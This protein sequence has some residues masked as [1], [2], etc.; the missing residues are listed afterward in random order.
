MFTCANPDCRKAFDY[1]Q[2]QLVRVRI[3][4]LK[5]AS[6][7]RL[8]VKHFWLCGDCFELYVLSLDSGRI[9]V[10]PRPKQLTAGA[11]NEGS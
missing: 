10:K 9:T 6:A 2:G 1:R 8:P 4:A 7:D 5:D 11:G 3:A